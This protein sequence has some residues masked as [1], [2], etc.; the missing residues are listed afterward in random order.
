MKAVS[1]F[2]ESLQQFEFKVPHTPVYLCT[3]HHFYSSSVNIPK[4]LSQQFVKKL[5]FQSIIKYLKDTGYDTFVECG[6]G[7]TVTKI[8]T[9]NF[10]DS[11]EIQAYSTD[12]QGIENIIKTLNE[13]NG[14]ILAKRNQNRTSL[15]TGNIEI[16]IIILWAQ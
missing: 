12:V 8:I 15:A 9:K 3:E 13:K 11:K 6:G 4:I 16:K 7:E 1:P 14:E 2:E 10:T 5:N